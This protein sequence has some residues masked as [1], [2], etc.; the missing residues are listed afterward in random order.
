MQALIA[1]LLALGGLYGATLLIADR[2]AGV[3]F[4][5]PLWCLGFLLLAVTLGLV[6]SAFSVRHVLRK[7][8]L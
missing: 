7:V 2:V 3:A 8:R 1:G 4:L 5:S 6:G